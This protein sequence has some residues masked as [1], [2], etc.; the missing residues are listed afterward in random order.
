MNSLS[1]PPFSGSARSRRGEHSS[2]GESSRGKFGIS[3]VK[4][5]VGAPPLPPLPYKY[6]YYDVPK[7]QQ[8]TARFGDIF[9][10][11]S[12]AILYHHQ[13][14]QFR[15]EEE[16]EEE[17]FVEQ[18][19]SGFYAVNEPTL[20]QRSLPETEVSEIVLSIIANWE[21]ESLRTWEAATR[22]IKKFIDQKLD[23]AGL[24]SYDI[25][26][27]IMAPEVRM[28]RYTSAVEY[29]ADLM[30]DWS[31]IKD[32]VF[33]VLQLFSSTKNQMT[34]ISLFRFGPSEI[35]SRNPITVYV[36]VS[37]DAA[38]NTWQPVIEAIQTYLNQLPYLLVL[39]LEHG[40]IIP[41]TFEHLPAVL[42][43]TRLDAKKS[44]LR[45]D[46]DYLDQPVPGNDISPAKYLFLPN[47]RKVNSA[48]GTFGCY[49]EI[50]T[51][52]EPT[53]TSYGLTNYHI[54]RPCIDGFRVRPS[55]TA[56][57]SILGSEAQRADLYGFVPPR[58][59]NM[60][61]LGS[62]SRKKHNYTLT[63]MSRRISDMEK[64]TDLVVSP[65]LIAERERKILFFEKGNNILGMPWCG[66]GLRARSQKNAR[67]DWALFRVEAA[68]LRSN[69]LPP[70]KD[71]GDY[72]HVEEELTTYSTTRLLDFH[73]DRSLEKLGLNMDAL[74]KVGA[75]S[76]KTAG[77][78]SNYK[79]DVR[80]WAEAG[81]FERSTECCVIT[82]SEQDMAQR[83]DSGS[84][85]YNTRGE[86]VGLVF[87]GPSHPTCATRYAFVTPIEDI[88]EH[89]KQLS[90]GQITDIRVAGC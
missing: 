54:V 38:E 43:D 63:D 24:D 90:K 40:S 15:P 42:P 25:R 28:K 45:I 77:L 78:V 68:R 44:I 6:E 51:I 29:N 69:I 2:S 9:T 11:Q 70:A 1:S 7:I 73:P 41:Y 5:R 71:W 26:V 72:P 86:L 67:L 19:D 58:T 48:L 59:G 61:T 46:T 10:R 12:E 52:S 39:H 27:E 34:S 31:G 18:I 56:D 55:G 65:E 4:Y 37:Y 88:F 89:V 83:G 22:D 32:H 3:A 13:I 53:W 62:P 16:D 33:S 8:L 14:T 76:G 84:V 75:M 20:C 85:A 50:K 57:G 47:G 30:R 81:D 36:S 82:G 79:S 87:S 17:E 64:K 23:D 21:S 49:I 35:R 60:A 80:M 66:S 74:L